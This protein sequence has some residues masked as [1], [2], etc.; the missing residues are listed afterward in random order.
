MLVEA[1]HA[2]ARGDA[3]LAK[4]IKYMTQVGGVVMV[5]NWPNYLAN[6]G[7]G[8]VGGGGMSEEEEAAARAAKVKEEK[9]RKEKEKEKM[10][11]DWETRRQLAQSKAEQQA[12]KDK[13]DWD[14]EASDRAFLFT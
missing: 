13:E 1:C 7:A 2:E 8:G 6:G 10:K 14:K 11:K 4:A 5:D 3:A 12:K 9:K